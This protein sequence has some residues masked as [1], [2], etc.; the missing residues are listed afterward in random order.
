MCN[1]VRLYDFS[2]IPHLVVFLTNLRIY[3]MLYVCMYVC[4]YTELWKPQCEND[5]DSEHIREDK[6]YRPK[7]NKGL[8]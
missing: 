8:L 1:Y 5:F 4:M 7:L 3:G 2:L 6:L